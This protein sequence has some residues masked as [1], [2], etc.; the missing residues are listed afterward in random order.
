MII[1]KAVVLAG[2]AG[3]R[4]RPL[5]NDRPKAMIGVLGKPVL[6]WVIEWLRKYG[7]TRL[8]I[9]VAYKK[10]ALMDYFG[11]GSKFGVEI[12]YSVHSVEGGTGE[13]FRLAISRFVNEDVFLAMNGDELTNLNIH[14]LIDFHLL[15]RPLATM[16]VTPLRSP[17]GIISID[18][19]GNITGFQEKPVISQ[20]LVNMGVY[21][22]DRKIINYLPERGTVEEK[23]FPL[24]AEKRLLKAFRFNG[25]WVT[26]NTI[27]D[28]QLAESELAKLTS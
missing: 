24:L 12:K 10:E 27:K 22:F 13:G 2:G 14:S 21:I 3:L 23:M 11:D 5:T 15:H 4:M 8:V 20:L 6:Q 17:Y 26:I 1:R 25:F 18:D 9:G 16:V 7:I 28:L 19:D